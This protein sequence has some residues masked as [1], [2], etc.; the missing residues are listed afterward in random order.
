M[1]KILCIGGSGQLGKCVIKSLR[2]HAI[3]NVDFSPSEHTNDNLLF[4]KNNTPSQNNQHAV[5]YFKKQKTIFNAIMV[6]AG[7]W[8]PG[9]VKD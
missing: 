7:G 8:A 1:K 5:E 9:S 4:S 2:N 6:T 3:T